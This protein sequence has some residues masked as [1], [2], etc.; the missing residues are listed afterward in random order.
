[1]AFTAKVTTDKLFL[2]GSNCVLH[3]H[4][5]HLCASLLTRNTYSIFLVYIYIYLCIY[6]P[7]FPKKAY[8][9]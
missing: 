7:L 8:A 1:M 2:S 6:V 3:C 5:N 4:L 9:K